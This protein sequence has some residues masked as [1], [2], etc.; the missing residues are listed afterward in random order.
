MRQFFLRQ[1]GCDR[2]LM[3]ANQ[4]LGVVRGI[5]YDLSNRSI[6]RSS[7][8][9]IYTSVLRLVSAK[10][11]TSLKDDPDAALLLVGLA[12]TDL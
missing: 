3:Q 10:T 9:A 5:P 8:P 1:V 6:V 7:R 4:H 2:L 12:D 11:P